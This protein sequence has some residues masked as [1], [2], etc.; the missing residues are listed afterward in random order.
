MRKKIIIDGKET[1]YSVTDDAHIF[2]DITGKELKG[3]YKT[4][5]YHSVQLVIE[6][7]PRTFMF[8]RLVAEAFI[9]NPNN[10]NI[11]DHIDRDKKNDNASNLRWT[12]N[13]G[14]NMNVD[15]RKPKQ[16][17][18]KYVGDF[19]DSDWKKVYG[20]EDT[21]VVDSNGTVIN[22]KTMN[23][24]I[25]QDRH[26][27]KRVNINN[28]YKSLHIIVWE[29]FNNQKVPGGMQ[30][31]HIDGD[32]SNNKLSNLKLVNSSENM[33]NAYKN[34]HESQVAVKQYSLL[35]EYIKTYP[36][37]REA[38]RENNLDH[39]AIRQATERY[40]TCGNYYW[41]RNNDSTKVQEIMFNWIPEGYKIIEKFPTYCINE[42]GQVYNKKNKTH[43]PIKI[44]TDGKPFVIIKGRR[45][46]ID[47]LLN[48][49][50]GMP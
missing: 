49:T 10:Y 26:G 28:T 25:P 1:N 5:E 12:D 2:N 32:K 33:K 47:E 18:K 27:Y 50:F 8:H 16:K 46:D 9:P 29:T 6:G 4:N 14:N 13:K 37:F 17:N 23:I 19:T 20:H 34:G 31:D 24:L 44:R 36:S 38:G 43:S 42:K 3:T 35:G 11:V 40:G 41:I 22:L 30:I 21:H 39:N 7:K 45:I 15:K 48:E